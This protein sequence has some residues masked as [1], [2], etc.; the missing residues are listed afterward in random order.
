MLYLVFAQL[1]QTAFRGLLR[2]IV[3]YISHD[4]RCQKMT[5]ANLTF[6]F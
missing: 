4:S 5:H 1:R 2:Q 6:H 3:Q